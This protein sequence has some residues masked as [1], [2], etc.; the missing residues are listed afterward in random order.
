MER[1]AKEIGSRTG[2]GSDILESEGK[3]NRLR[4]KRGSGL[5][6]WKGRM[7]SGQDCLSLATNG[8]TLECKFIPIL[9][10]QK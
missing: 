7:I 4:L 5:N 2:G 6:Q 9:K 10:S 8:L 1:M 3:R